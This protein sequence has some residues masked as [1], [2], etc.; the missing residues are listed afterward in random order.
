[1]KN[2]IIIHWDSS[3][4]FFHVIIVKCEVQVDGLESSTCV[5]AEFG[6]SNI[7]LSKNGGLGGFMDLGVSKN[8]G[9]PKWMVYNGKPY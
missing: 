7:H 2:M 9:T 1:M 5:D 8:R 6:S 4:I 3:A